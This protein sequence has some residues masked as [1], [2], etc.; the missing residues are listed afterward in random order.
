MNVYVIIPHFGSPK[1]TTECLESV[2]RHAPGAC[3]VVVD[4]SGDFEYH[5][6]SVKVLKPGRNLGYAGGCNLGMTYACVERQA[7]YVLILNNDAA[8]TKYGSIEGLVRLCQR[9]PNA[10]IV[11]PKIVAPDG[12]VQSCGGWVNLWTGQAGDKG[13]CKPSDE[14]M[15]QE[16]ADY[17]S[18]CCML[19]PRST[20]TK[21][22]GFEEKYYLYYED[23]DY[24]F[25]A[26]KKGLHVV[27]D[28]Q[29]TVV[30]KGGSSSTGA[31]KY[32]YSVRNQ[33]LFMRTHAPK[34]NLLVFYPQ[35]LA[36]YTASALINLAR[37]QVDVCQAVLAGARDAFTGKVGGSY[38]Q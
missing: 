33:V 26:R 14:F 35:Y 20:W 2:A 36:R 4:N 7:D 5:D 9:T 28:E 21:I 18:G 12:R 19:I 13:R 16:L 38:A 25:R 31:F 32:Y 1:D 30:H 27:I 8:L 29:T 3:R 10:G 24:C 22:G 11:A 6:T 17:A 37:G 34:F 23:V 15:G